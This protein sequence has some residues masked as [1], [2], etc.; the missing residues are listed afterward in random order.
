[1]DEQRLK[2]IRERHNQQPPSTTTMAEWQDV[3]YLLSLLPVQPAPQE[4]DG[5]VTFGRI[6]EDVENETR[7][8]ERIPVQ[9]A[10][11]SARNWLIEAEKVK[12]MFPNFGWPDR[13]SF[14]EAV[15]EQLVQMTRL[16]VQPAAST[17][18]KCKH[19]DHEFCPVCAVTCCDCA[20]VNNISVAST[21]TGCIRPLSGGGREVKNVNCHV[22]DNLGLCV[23]CGVTQTD[24]IRNAA[25]STEAQD[26]Q[27]ALRGKTKNE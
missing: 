12:G 4:D 5:W 15:A 20:T 14:S 8:F 17:P 25:A 21:P 9:P 26:S 27:R 24:E 7:T 22:F 3:E 19:C 18:T 6:T 10:R 13:L 1:M 2:E 16:P 11:D 23:Y